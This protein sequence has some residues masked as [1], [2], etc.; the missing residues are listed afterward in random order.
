[1]QKLF[2]LLTIIGL[3]TVNFAL[4]ETDLAALPDPELTNYKTGIDVLFGGLRNVDYAEEYFYHDKLIDDHKVVYLKSTTTIIMKHNDRNIESPIDPTIVGINGRDGIPDSGDEGIIRFKL[5]RDM[6]Y[7]F[8]YAGNAEHDFGPLPPAYSQPFTL[9]E[10]EYEFNVPVVGTTGPNQR[11][12]TE[13]TEHYHRG[14]LDAFKDEW[15]TF[16]FWDDD[17]YL[18]GYYS[19]HWSTDGKIIQFVVDPKTPLISF[20]PKTESAQF[21]TTPAKT[22]YVP[23]IHE[24]TSY[25]TD[26]IDIELINI[27]N[28]DPIWYRFDS[29]QFT[30]YSEPI[31]SNSL[32]DGTHVLEYYYDES[33]HKT[34]TVV[35]NPGYPS[36]QDIFVDGTGHGYLMWENETK[37][38]ELQQRLLT[39]SL[40]A[41]YKGKRD[42]DSVYGGNGH[43]KI[44]ALYR[45]GHRHDLGFALVNAI[46]VAMEGANQRPIHAAQAKKCLLDNILSLDIVGS[47]NAGPFKPLPFREREYRGYY[48]VNVIYDKAFAYDLLIKYFRADQH[49]G[50]I[51]PIEDL[52][53]R[54]LL[55]TYPYESMLEFAGF[56]AGSPLEPTT[57]SSGGMWNNAKHTGS[58]IAALA[59]PSY[60]T[61]YFGTSGFD[62]RTATHPWTPFPDHPAS[63]ADIFYTHTDA[64][65]TEVVAR[66]Y[67]YPNQRALFNPFDGGLVSTTPIPVNRTL[68]D[69]TKIT[70][71]P[72]GSFY[73]RPAYYGYQMMGHTF[74]I[75]S[76]V[77]KIRLHYRYPWLEKSFENANKGQLFGRKISTPDDSDPRYFWQFILINERFP[78]IAP[79][80]EEYLPFSSEQRF[81][82]ITGSFGL[83]WHNPEWRDYITD[84]RTFTLSTNAV[85]GS[86]Q[87]NPDKPVYA[88]GEKVEVTAVPNA[89]YAF[90]Y[91]NNNWYAGKTTNP[92]ALVMSSDQAITAY[93]K[94]ITLYGDISG[95][96]II[97][98]YDAALVAQASVGLL[99]LTAA[100]NQAA[101]VSGDVIVSA[102]DA[103]LIAQRAVGLI[104]KFPVEG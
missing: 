92:R 28:H 95:D 11:S 9:S 33:F 91:W 59:M 67:G 54:D 13:K 25:I 74:Q 84:A 103:A 68:T 53:I 76:N 38:S 88:Y 22:Y 20:R 57:E 15:H 24:Q 65:N 64:N 56:T 86:I 75:L 49:A 97:S 35:K 87:K 60:D 1:M 73:D 7:K 63:W 5:D 66:L 37:Y 23:V 80:A 42:T 29:E 34:R 10:L 30:Q 62:G 4:A 83:V 51:T 82:Y 41:A 32:T 98:A 46:V 61:L 8:A 58:I 31:S 16:T 90:D 21:Y 44:N 69:G 100:Q 52:K 93:F 19:E 85:G 89:G 55:A 14:M 48:D 94:L 101:E 2:I 102:Y 18:G 45:S 47:E 79:G 26:D 99:T 50:G 27:M 96:A 3:L 12:I 104:I 78:N 72:A 70:E 81:H 43:T 17:S 36:D 6:Q 77:M 39:G 71:L 40:N